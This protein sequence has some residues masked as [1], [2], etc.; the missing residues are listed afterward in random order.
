MGDLGLSTGV[1]GP[2]VGEQIWRVGAA[3]LFL[4][5]DLGAPGHEQ[6]DLSITSSV[7]PPALTVKVSTPVGMPGGS[8]RDIFN[9]T[10]IVVGLVTSDRRIAQD[11]RSWRRRQRWSRLG[12]TGVDADDCTAASSMFIVA[13]HPER[14]HVF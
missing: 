5:N 3:N 11:P 4:C 9:V 8:I 6:L 13:V 1:S 10:S 2:V 12:G 14:I 7:P